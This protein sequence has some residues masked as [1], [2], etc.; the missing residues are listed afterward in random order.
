MMKIAVGTKNKAKLK[1]VEKVVQ[2]TLTNEFE[3]Q[4]ISVEVFQMKFLSYH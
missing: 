4:A 1:A 3:I 2:D